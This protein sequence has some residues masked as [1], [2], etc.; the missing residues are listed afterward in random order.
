MA[1]PNGGPGRAFFQYSIINQHY[2]FPIVINLVG[3]SSDHSQVA[4]IFRITPINVPFS[5]AAAT[6]SLSPSCLLTAS[7]VLCVPALILTSTLNLGGSACSKRTRTPSPMTVASE[8]CVIVGVISTSTVLMRALGDEGGLMWMSGRFTTAREP[9]ES[10]C[11]GSE[12]VDMRSASGQQ[13]TVAQAKPS[14]LSPI[15]SLQ[16]TRVQAVAGPRRAIQLMMRNSA[17]SRRMG[18]SQVA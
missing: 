2:Q 14:V 17:Y 1:N 18:C 3:R 7:S 12:I 6:L 9:R 4:S 11:S 13:G 8:Q 10:G 16:R 15:F 5:S